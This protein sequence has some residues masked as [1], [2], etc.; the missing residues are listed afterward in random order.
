[1]KTVTVEQI[2]AVIE[3]NIECDPVPAKIRAYL[4][5]HEGKKLTKRDEKQMQDMIDPSL[6]FATVASMSQIQWGA[7]D[8]SGGKTGGSVL[9]S[10][11]G[12]TVDLVAFDRQNVCYFGAA[13]ERN[14]KRA[15]ALANPPLLVDLANYI[16]MKLRADAALEQLFSDDRPL[17]PDQYSIQ[18]LYEDK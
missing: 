11:N 12:W 14:A 4:G 18:K 9:F 5:L 13:D 1:M 17:S 3:A 16:N 10:Y 8:R 6:R 2:R 15:E 7:R